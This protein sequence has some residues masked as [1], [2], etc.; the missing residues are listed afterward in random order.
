MKSNELPLM[1]RLKIVLE[2]RLKT[3][4][5]KWNTAPETDKRIADVRKS[6]VNNILWGT[7]F[8]LTRT[9]LREKD[10]TYHAFF[11]NMTGRD[12]KAQFTS[13][14]IPPQSQEYVDAV[15]VLRNFAY[16][17]GVMAKRSQNTTN[18]T[19]L[20][21]VARG[22]APTEHRVEVNDLGRPTIPSGVAV[23]EETEFLQERIGIQTIINGANP[24]DLQKYLEQHL[25]PRLSE[26]Q[27]E[28]N[29]RRK[30]LKNNEAT[31]M[32]Y[33]AHLADH[34]TLLKLLIEQA[35]AKIDAQTPALMTDEDTQP[36]TETRMKYT[37]YPPQPSQTTAVPKVRAYDAALEAR[38]NTQL[39]EF[40]AKISARVNSLRGVDLVQFT[41]TI[42]TPKLVKLQSEIAELTENGQSPQ[43]LRLKQRQ[44]T[45]IQNGLNNAQE[46]D[47]NDRLDTLRVRIEKNIS[48]ATFADLKAY[49][50]DHLV[51]KRR[52]L[53]AELEALPAEERQSFANLTKQRHLDVIVAGI[54]SARARMTELAMQNK[55]AS[56]VV[57]LPIIA[58][59][60]AQTPVDVEGQG[61]QNL[62]AAIFANLFLNRGE[63]IAEEIARPKPATSAIHIPQPANQQARAAHGI[64]LQKPAERVIPPRPTSRDVSDATNVPFVEKPVNQPQ[65]TSPWIKRAT[66]AVWIAAMGVIGLTAGSIFRDGQGHQAPDM[67]K[68][69]ATASA[70]VNAEPATAQTANLNGSMGPVFFEAPLASQKELDTAAK[71]D[72]VAR[73]AP[74][75][76]E[77]QVKASVA[78]APVTKPAKAQ[79][80]TA[81]EASNTNE[82]KP[83][84][85]ASFDV[86]T[87]RIDLETWKNACDHLKRQNMTVEGGVCPK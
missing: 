10:D 42:L 59:N 54:N 29:E 27:K 2:D 84:I 55:P 78:K 39:A 12:Y 18:D 46:K 31:F 72:V 74:Q 19:Y 81:P 49:S 22:I 30:S 52:A 85:L 53:E 13:T 79:K 33:F 71:F 73:A 20:P 60:P 51:P 21:W 38:A 76:D 67:S 41:T 9:Q 1:D 34:E 24:T 35:E 75:P 5:T 32:T 25:K 23:H 68:A 3:L 69:F 56:P 17:V 87:S 82:A 66:V 28:C 65:K 80:V 62:K 58:Q 6:A 7:Q 77:P 43:M 61:K 63:R 45:I 48:G 83:T 57:S 14:H 37:E 40:G 47:L 86:A 70:K 36:K 15:K 64:A 4:A 26:I 11:D 50:R 44:L 16:Y 8:Q